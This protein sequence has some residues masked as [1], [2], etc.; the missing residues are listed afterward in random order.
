VDGRFGGT[1]DVLGRRLHR[2]GYRLVD[3]H[4]PL[5]DRATLEIKI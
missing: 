2:L 3:V 4:A 5:L 1:V